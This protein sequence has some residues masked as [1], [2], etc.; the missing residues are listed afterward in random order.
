MALFG[1]VSGVAA[2]SP[3]IQPSA[4]VRIAAAAADTIPGIPST[5]EWLEIT[6]ET[7]GSLGVEIL[8]KVDVL[9]DVKALKVNGKLNSADATTLK[10][11][12]QIEYLDLSGASLTTI[13]AECFYNRTSLKGIVL[14]NDLETIGNQAFRN[15]SLSYITIP[16]SVKSMGD[17]MLAF[18]TKLKEVKVESGIDIPSYF[19]QECKVLE[20]VEIADGP[21]EIG[22]Y[23]FYVCESLS[24][25]TLPSTLKTIGQYAFRSTKSL[26]DIV[27]PEG[28]TAIRNAAFQYSGLKKISLPSMAGLDQWVFSHCPSLEE[29]VLPANFYQ[30]TYHLFAYS[31]ALK[32]I[33]CPMLIPPAITE[34]SSFYDVNL[35]K[36]TLVVPDIA[37][38]NYKLDSFWKGCGIIEGGAKY[39][40]IN[41]KKELS[42]ANNRRPESPV[43]VNLYQ[44]GKLTVGGTAAFP[45]TNLVL[46]YAPSYEYGKNSFGQIINSSPTTTAKSG[47]VSVY[48]ESGKWY[49]IT[50]PTDVKITDISIPEQVDIAVREYDGSARAAN[51][52]GN[53]WKDLSHTSVMKKG[54][55]YIVQVQ[56]NQWVELHLS[57]TGCADLLANTDRVLTPVAH[58]SDN[59][60]DAGWNLL[61]NPWPSFFDLS[62]SDVNSPVMIWDSYNKK[63]DAYSPLDDKI[64][65]QPGQAFFIQQTEDA[66]LTLSAA[67]RCFTSEGIE[68]ETEPAMETRGMS[69]RYLFDL[70]VSD[71]EH[72][73]RTRVVFNPDAS[74]EYEIGRD[75]SKFFSESEDVPAIYTV[76]SDGNPLAINERPYADRSVNLFFETAK[77]GKYSLS[78]A[79]AD[80]TV[81]ILDR[82]TGKVT[83]LAAGVSMQVELPGKGE[84]SSRYVALLQES[85]ISAVEAVAG[86]A[87]NIRVNVAGNIVEVSGATGNV[88][89][90]S[91]DG[92]LVEA[93]EGDCRFSL[94]AGVYV[95]RAGK[96]SVKCIVR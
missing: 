9:G 93:A 96:S 7:P 6:T 41:L 79:R 78:V 52:R 16:S 24:Q 12:T 26:T 45:I 48:M 73:D 42:L 74:M 40:V 89:V 31:S 67:G 32:K 28:L 10:N 39:D 59:D 66:E 95:V 36:I 49:F 4:N 71:G 19:C 38:V 5:V 81:S 62:F 63:Y 75:A 65:L 21:A 44:G 43:A 50:P 80:G 34:S 92:R 58:K 56:K 27:L 37:V 55:G 3:A 29:V 30:D 72:S 18:N 94:A 88:E 35:S 86:A 47:R 91:I 53:S 87:E 84:V 14:P 83:P 17:Y 68:T 82:V 22:I 77:E 11:L 33:E 15:T 61:G 70:E 64:V 90:F 25:V 20:K 85:A 51:G 54:V 60:A 8:Y 76:D 1:S 13:P 2:A 69:Q 46:D 57:E 23:A